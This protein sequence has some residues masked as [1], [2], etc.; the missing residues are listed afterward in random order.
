MLWLAGLFN[1]QRRETREVVPQFDRPYVTDAS[2]FEATF[3]PIAVTPHH[4]AIAET[5]AWLR[6]I[7]SV[8]P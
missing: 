5:V 7:E 1:A 3:G 6:G 4:E 8:A 2:A